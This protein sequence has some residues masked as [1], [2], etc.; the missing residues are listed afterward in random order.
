MNL[1]R[2]GVRLSAIAAFAA[3]FSTGAAS[4]DVGPWL[5]DRHSKDAT[6]YAATMNESGGMLGKVCGADGCQWILTLS[7]NCERGEEYAA[8]VTSGNGAGHINLICTP[9]DAKTARYTIK[10]YSV[11]ESAVRGGPQIGFAMPMRSGQFR[12]ARFDTSQAEQAMK[13]LAARLQVL[14][15]SPRESNL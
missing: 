14:M 8:L 4:Q 5:V 1:S 3:V 9:N 10:E 12:V 2:N 7:A 15:R 11:I 6:V 13:N